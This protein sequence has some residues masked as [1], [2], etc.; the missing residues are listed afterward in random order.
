MHTVF[1]WLNAMTTIQHVL[2]F[3]AVTVQEWPQFDGGIYHN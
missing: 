1:T 3:D 2:K